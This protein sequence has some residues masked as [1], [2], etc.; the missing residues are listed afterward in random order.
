MNANIKTLI[1]HVKNYMTQHEK[2]KKERRIER[3]QR[4]IER[5]ELEEKMRRELLVKRR[6]NVRR[7]HSWLEPQSSPRY[8]H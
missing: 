3:L 1:S 2:N 6:S 7:Q 8:Y 5:E 4:A